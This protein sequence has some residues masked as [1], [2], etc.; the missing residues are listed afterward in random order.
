MTEIDRIHQYVKNDVDFVF[1][2]A[3]VFNEA[4][5]KQQIAQLEFERINGT[6]SKRVIPG[7][8]VYYQFS[9]DPYDMLCIVCYQFVDGEIFFLN[10]E[11]NIAI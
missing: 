5:L 7:S 10:A 11:S 2:T 6:Q 1:K 3:S 8:I 9:T 4:K